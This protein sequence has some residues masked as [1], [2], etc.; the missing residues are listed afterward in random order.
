MLSS[1]K[2][3]PIYCI[4]SSNYPPQL[5]NLN[6]TC[7]PLKNP[8]ALTVGSILLNRLNL[9]QINLQSPTLLHRLK[10]QVQSLLVMEEGMMIAVMI[11]VMIAANQVNLTMMIKVKRAQ[12]YK[13]I[14]LVVAA[15]LH[16]LIQMPV[17]N[18]VHQSPENLERENQ[19]KR[20]L[21]LRRKIEPTDPLSLAY[22]KHAKTSPSS[23]YPFIQIQVL[24]ERGSEIG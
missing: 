6:P 24:E 10:H 18:L 12:C 4:L 15:V 17:L 14:P 1:A 22:P 2:P 13:I 23:R 19:R 5:G 20:N 8:K 9:L 7:F 21:S 11:A 16:H 3:R